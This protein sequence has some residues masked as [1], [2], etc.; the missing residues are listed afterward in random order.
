MKTYGEWI[1]PRSLDLGT[2][3][4]WV[5]SFTPRPLYPRR[6]GPG[7]S[8]TEGRVDLRTIL[9]FI[10]KTKLL[11]LPE[12]EH[13]SFCRSTRSQ[14]LYQLR[15]PLGMLQLSEEEWMT[16]RDT[17]QCRVLKHGV[18]TQ[19]FDVWLCL[20]YLAARKLSLEWFMFAD[21][22]HHS[23][24]FLCNISQTTAYV[25]IRA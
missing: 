11:T 18:P 19:M 13:S 7:T 25:R 17:L 10:K 15:H 8:W 9:D 3:W 12:L 24:C 5:D 22:F 20:C 21:S 14:L 2:S 1:D 16:V 4:R 6:K 23:Q